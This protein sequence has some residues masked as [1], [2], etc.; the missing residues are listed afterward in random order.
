M[1]DERPKTFI[2]LAAIFTVYTL[3]WNSGLNSVYY[4]GYEL[5]C[6]L[7]VQQSPALAALR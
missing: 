7:P 2:M 3:S 1:S 5:G 6:G 4:C